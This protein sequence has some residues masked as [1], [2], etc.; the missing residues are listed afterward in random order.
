MVAGADGAELARRQAGELALRLE[1]RVPISS[2]T[3]WSPAAVV[4]APTPNEIRVK[5][6][7]MIRGRS[8]ATSS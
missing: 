4:A 6:A 3:G 8:T 7:S 2:I 5:T 1:R